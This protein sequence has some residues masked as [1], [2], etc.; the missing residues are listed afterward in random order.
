MTITSEIRD[1]VR[2]R[3]HFACEFCG[4]TE[5]DAGGELTVDHFQPTAK[6]G[7]MAL[8]TYSTVASAAT[9]TSSITGRCIQMIHHCGILVASQRHNTFS[10][11][12]T[13]HCT[14]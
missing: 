13:E 1:Q 2:Q 4:V 10:N 14:L 5:T 7:M 9:S 12:T 3:A 11:W 6:G 8:E